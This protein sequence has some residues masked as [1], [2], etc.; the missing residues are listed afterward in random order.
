MGECKLELQGFLVQ[1]VSV[2]RYEGQTRCTRPTCVMRMV[3]RC[4]TS[5]GN[6]RVLDQLVRG[7]WVPQFKGQ[8]RGARPTC[9]RCPGA[10]LQRAIE[11]CSTNLCN[12]SRQSNRLTR[13]SPELASQP[14][15][16]KSLFFEI[17]VLSR[18]NKRSGHQ[19][20]MLTMT[21]K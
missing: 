19:S 4:L 11:G 15:I 6:R 2:P 12:V 10:S 18:H 14:L 8:S 20:I 13:A 3:F 9:A 1:G 16:S 5:K 17:S 7:V 21:T